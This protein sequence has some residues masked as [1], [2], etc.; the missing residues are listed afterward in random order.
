MSSAS[1][2]DDIVRVASHEGLALHRAY[3]R[4]PSLSRLVDAVL[5]T[6]EPWLEHIQGDRRGQ[7]TTILR[8]HLER[9]GCITTLGRRR[10]RKR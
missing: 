3:G 1:L 10:R 9:Q 5:S 4:M 2:T 6:K 7:V 8:A